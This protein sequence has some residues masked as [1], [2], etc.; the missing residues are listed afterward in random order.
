MLHSTPFAKAGVPGV[1]P[2]PQSLA[3][4]VSVQEMAGRCLERR[5]VLGKVVGM[6]VCL[7]YCC[8]CGEGLGL[9]AG[10]SSGL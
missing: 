9:Q 8:P 10:T 6:G 3:W 7:G 4:S 1:T 2:R 5:R